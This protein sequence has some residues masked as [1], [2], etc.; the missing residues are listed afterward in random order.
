MRYKH[1]K[2]DN[3]RYCSCVTNVAIPKFETMEDAIDH[4]DVLCQNC[5]DDGHEHTEFDVFDEGKLVW[6]GHEKKCDK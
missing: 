6:C 2:I 3:C 4:G 5:A 1:Y